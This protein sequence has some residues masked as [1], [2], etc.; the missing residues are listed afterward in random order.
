MY[1]AAQQINY[2]EV[3]IEWFALLPCIA[4]WLSVANANTEKG[5]FNRGVSGGIC[6]FG[7]SCRGCLYEGFH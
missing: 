2:P 5:R 6:I 4:S 1:V 7:T 3:V